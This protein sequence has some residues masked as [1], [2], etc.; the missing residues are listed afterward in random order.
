[1]IITC[2]GLAISPQALPR[3]GPASPEHGE[4]ATTGDVTER[5]RDERLVHADG[6]DDRRVAVSVDEANE[7][8]SAGS[9]LS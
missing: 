7:T 1:V 5:V 6:P 3:F 8:S 9:A 4:T 2:R